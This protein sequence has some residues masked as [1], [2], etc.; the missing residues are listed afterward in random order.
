MVKYRKA[1]GFSYTGPAN[2]AGAGP[3]VGTGILTTQMDYQNVQPDVNVDGIVNVPVD[4]DS[5]GNDT[6][7]MGFQ[8]ERLAGQTYLPIFTSTGGAL[9]YHGYI[10]QGRS[11]MPRGMGS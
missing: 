8:A 1:L 3:G 5:F 11:R 6:G 10:Q 9:P 7:V 4:L 2:S